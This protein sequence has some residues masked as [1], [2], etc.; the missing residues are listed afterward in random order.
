MNKIIQT[1]QGL[2][3]RELAF[4]FEGAFPNGGYAVTHERKLAE[5]FYITDNVVCK[6]IVPKGGVAFGAAGVFAAMLVPKTAVHKDDHIVAQNVQIRGTRQ[7]ATVESITNPPFKEGT[8]HHHFGNGILGMDG[9][10]HLRTGERL[11]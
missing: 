8:T 9:A 7:I 5:G 4:P 2:L 6:L 11:L 1:F 3:R 10:H